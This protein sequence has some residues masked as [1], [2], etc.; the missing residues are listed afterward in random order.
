MLISKFSTIL[1][2]FLWPLIHWQWVLLISSNRCFVYYLILWK[3]NSNLVKPKCHKKVL[4]QIHNIF[5]CQMK[6]ECFTG[7]YFLFFRLFVCMF[8]K[9]C[10]GCCFMFCYVLAVLFCFHF[11]SFFFSFVF[12]LFCFCWDVE[13]WCNWFGSKT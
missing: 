1:P 8:F 13:R 12:F 4:L 2:L 7:I 9:F 11:I 6:L 5:L 10:S 3:D